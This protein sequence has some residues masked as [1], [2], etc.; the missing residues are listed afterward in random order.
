[1]T[2]SSFTPST[3]PLAAEA[4]HPPVRITGETRSASVRRLCIHRIFQRDTFTNCTKLAR[5]L[6]VGSRTILRD[7]EA[8]RRG[9]YPIEYDARRRRYFYAEPMYCLPNIHVSESDLIAMRTAMA[10]LPAAALAP[11]RHRVDKMCKHLGSG[12]RTAL[13]AMSFHHI[14][15]AIVAP[16]IV[17]ALVKSIARHEEVEFDYRKPYSQRSRRYTVR[18]MLVADSDNLLYLAARE[19]RTLT[20]KT[21]ALSRIRGKVRPTGQIFIERNQEPIEGIFRNS[22]RVFSGPVRHHIV[23]KVNRRAAPYIR[24]R[25]WHKSQRFSPSRGGSWLM[26]MDLSDLRDLRSW[27]LRWG[28]DIEVLAPQLLRTMVRK[29]AAKTAAV[30]ASSK[31][32]RWELKSAFFTSDTERQE[33]HGKNP[34]S[35]RRSRAKSNCDCWT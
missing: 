3:V 1:M 16:E 11:M 27:I 25:Q 32:R 7:I 8:M 28:P 24:E 5:E 13:P 10:A 4:R 21:F 12:R 26:E 20:L 18:P 6:E 14:G 31:R 23:L 22:F 15:D 35:W 33:L 29:A 34:P 17:A 2:T 9:D 30:Y 19:V